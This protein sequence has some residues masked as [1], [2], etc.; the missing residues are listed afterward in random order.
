M[1]LWRV[2]YATTAQDG[3]TTV[4]EEDFYMPDARDVRRTLR[5]R[6]LYPISIDQRKQSN[7][8]WFDTRSRS[9][10]LQLLRALRF[11][12]ATS[13]AGTAL[14][15]IVENETDPDRRIA[16]LPTRSV[17][18]GGGSFS[19]ALRVLKLFD[20]AT[21]AIII[22]GEKAGDLKGV[23]HHAIQHIEQKGGQMK[24]IMAAMGWLAFDIFTVISTIF[25]THF[26]FIP[27]L[28]SKGIESTNA[29]DVEKFNKA[30]DL[31]ETLNLIMLFICVAICL[32][33]LAFA[34]TYYVNRG[35]KD[36]AA[37]KLLTKMPLFSPYLRDTALADTCKLTA[38]LLRGHVPLDEALEIISESS[39][40]PEVQEFWSK[41]RERLRAG[42]PPARALA[43]SPLN[44]VEQDQIAT[45]QQ[46]SQIAEVMDS[47]AEERA[48]GAKA[49]QR[50]IMQSGL[51]FM[52][53][54]GGLT[55]LLMIYLIM[56]Q[57]QGF[58]DSL[59][60]MRGGG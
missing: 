12:T 33:V 21:M 15:N 57:N 43:R 44:K 42:A 17:L 36:H 55:V 19:D 16:F 20:A 3:S 51:I 8:E 45:A 35:K 39:M 28:R 54:F 29:E 26:G 47:I 13:S 6:G 5:M 32:A 4:R 60:Q 37:S 48:N 41:S 40:F 25:S 46:V 11:Q 18:K 59:N 31:G 30:V 52:M 1:R 58:M 10:Q 34:V 24:I 50:K 7:V 22:A 53:L 56:T 14:L 27:W 23:I 2:R 9:W 49:A 38:R